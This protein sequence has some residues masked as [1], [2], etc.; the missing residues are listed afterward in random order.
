MS[1]TEYPAM[2]DYDDLIDYDEDMD[3]NLGPSSATHMNEEMGM[4]PSASASTTAFR[5][6]LLKPELIRAIV[7]CGFEHPSEVQQQCIP[8][9]MLGLDTLCQ[10]KSGTGKTAV[11]VLST[12]QQ[13]YPI[14]GQVSAIVL[15]NTHEL[16]YQIKGEFTRF[17][18]YMPEIRSE[19]FYGGKPIATDQAILVNKSRIPHVV[20]GTPGRVKDLIERRYLKVEH[21]KHFILDECDKMLEGDNMRRDVQHIFKAC[22]RAKQVM[23]FSATISELLRSRCRLFMF[24]PLEVYVDEDSKFTL[25][26]LQQHYINLTESEKNRKLSELLDGLLFNQVFIFVKSVERAIHLDRILKSLK[27]PSIA[28]HAQMAQDTRMEHFKDFKDLKTRIAVSTDVFSRGM[29]V[30]RVNVVINYD[31]PLDADTYLHRVGR[32]GRFGT[33]GLAISFVSSDDN[34]AVLQSVQDRFEVNIP[35]MPDMLDVADYMNA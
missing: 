9:S 22:P 34:K 7:E 29:D 31:F 11:F 1:A 21:I 8:Q 16:A 17:C 2:N 10:A 35:E 5:D 30:S 14:D 27:F 28:I 33:K 13:L 24:K 19:V 12:L 6:L 4:D 18:K 26:G 23:M 15:C 25:N 3:L 32:A 20:V